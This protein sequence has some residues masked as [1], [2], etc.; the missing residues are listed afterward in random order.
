MQ[1]KNEKKIICAFWGHAGT[2]FSQVD[3]E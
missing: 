1:E 2:A 3:E